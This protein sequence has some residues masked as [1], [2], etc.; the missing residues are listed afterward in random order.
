MEAE[1][2]AWALWRGMESDLVPVL[3]N[4]I[5]SLMYRLRRI[6]LVLFCFLKREIQRK[7]EI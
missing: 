7:D 5:S 4:Y 1:K 6:G 3:S 2:D